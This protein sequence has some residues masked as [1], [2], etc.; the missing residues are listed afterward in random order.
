MK[1]VRE[2]LRDLAEQ[3]KESLSELIL[4]HSKIR[5]W[6]NPRSSV[7]VTLTPFRW[8]P[9]SQEGTQL[10]SKVLQDYRYF[11]DLMEVLLVEQPEQV[12]RDFEKSVKRTRDIIAQLATFLES[13]EEAHEKVRDDIDFQVSLIDRLY[14]PSGGVHIL[15]PDTNALLYNPDL[16]KWGFSKIPKFTIVLTPTVLSELDEHKINH[17]NEDVRKKADGLIR[18]IKDYR[19]RGPLSEGVP[20]KKGKITLM[21][22][23]K[24]PDF[25]RTLP[26]LDSS[27]LDD[28]YL[29][30]FLEVMFM[31]PGSVTALVTRDINLQNKAEFARLPFLEPPNPCTC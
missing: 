25:S 21:S 4:G 7:F 12:K 8:E 10:Q 20:I 28:R 16:E 14:D 6:H 27:N 29:A 3:V 9:L 11:C 30:S 1:S 17:R 24:E 26:W 2:N 31:F 15:V 22:V 13:S 18:R 19:R 23:A 5:R